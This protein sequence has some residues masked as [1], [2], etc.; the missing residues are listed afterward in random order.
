LNCS[1]AI[2]FTHILASKRREIIETVQLG[3]VS[4]RAVLWRPLQDQTP[5]ELVCRSNRSEKSKVGCWDFRVISQDD[6]TGSQG[7]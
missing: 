1:K 6:K 3:P 4:K 7:G 5:S 2:F